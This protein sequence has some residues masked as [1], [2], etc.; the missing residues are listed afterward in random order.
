MYAFSLGRN[1]GIVR[2]YWT[3]AKQTPSDKSPPPHSVCLYLLSGASVSKGSNGFFPK[4][5]VTFI[6][7][8]LVPLLSSDWQMSHGCGNSNILGVSTTTHALPFQLQAMAS[9]CLLEETHR[10]PQVAMV[11]CNYGGRMHGSLTL[12]FFFLT[13]KAVAMGTTVPGLAASLGLFAI[14]VCM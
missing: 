8:G 13:S 4:L 9:Q 1:G 14:S 7:L 12:A 5:P 11:T 2:K 10:W 6:S 3:K